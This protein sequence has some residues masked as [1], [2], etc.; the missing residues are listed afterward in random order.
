MI[1]TKVRVKDRKGRMKFIVSSEN[2]K[3][4][5][6]AKG[7]FGENGVIE[8]YTPS[9]ARAFALEVSQAANS[10]NPDFSQQDLARAIREDHAGHDRQFMSKRTGLVTDPPTENLADCT[11]E[12]CNAL[13]RYENRTI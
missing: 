10:E 12:A 4:Y 8:A 11:S 7:G 3:V 5:I 6:E 2:G 13:A 1:V 9:E